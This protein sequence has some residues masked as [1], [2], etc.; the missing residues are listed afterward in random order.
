MGRGNRSS[1]TRGLRRSEARRRSTS[2]AV[3]ARECGEADAS[4][5]PRAGLVA[6]ASRATPLRR[7]FAGRA[8]SGASRARCSGLGNADQGNKTEARRRPRA[9][10]NPS[11]A[12]P[13][14]ASARM[15]TVV[16]SGGTRRGPA[17]GVSPSPARRG[18]VRRPL[19]TDAE[20]P[21]A[22]TRAVVSRGASPRS[23]RI[24]AGGDTPTTRDSRA[25]SAPV[26]A[27]IAGAPRGQSALS[28]STR[29]RAS[30]RAATHISIE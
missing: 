12:G 7:R 20:L 15:Q 26:R 16:V 17:R 22:A 14:I 28:P 24:H 8:P 13:T 18:A 6:A 3:S 5:S 27:P 4:E 23:S 30:P 11:A 2:R 19:T 29:A 9:L 10:G 25:T 1:K 21:P